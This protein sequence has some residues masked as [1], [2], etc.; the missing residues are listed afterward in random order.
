MLAFSRTRLSRWGLLAFLVLN[1]FVAV[2]IGFFLLESRAQY[3]EKAAISAQNLSQLLEQQLNASIRQIDI[4]LRSVGDVVVRAL[5]EGKS[6]EQQKL[7]GLLTQHQARQP[8][9]DRILL[10]DAR[11]RIVASS[12]FESSAGGSLADT[13]YFRRVSLDHYAGLVVGRP[14]PDPLGHQLLLPFAR[15]I[16]HSDGSFAGSLVVLAEVDRFARALTQ[17]RVGGRGTVTLLDEEQRQIAHHPRAKGERQN[18]G[19]SQLE[20]LLPLL[21]PGDAMMGNAHELAGGDGIH[22]LALRKSADWPFLIAVD[23]MSEDYLAPWYKELRF[24]LVAFLL[25]AILTGAGAYVIVRVWCAHEQA[26]AENLR[27]LRFNEALLKAIPV[28]VFFKDRDG[29][30]LGCNPAY[31]EIL[32]VAPADLIGRTTAEVWP[33][34]LSDIYVQKDR[35]LIA[36]EAPQVYEF[37][38]RDR[39]GDPRQVIFARNIF[40]DEK[41]D[42]AG[43]IGAFID[44]TERKRH[45][46]ELLAA[47]EV[48]EAASLAKSQFLATMSHEIRTPLNGILGMAQIMLMNDA[49]DGESR[50]CAQTIFNSG[51]MLLT[52]LNDILDLSKIEAG[53][54]QLEVT[55]FDPGQLIRDTLELFA[56]AAERQGVLLQGQWEEHFGH[57]YQGDPTRLRQMLGNLVSNAIKFSHGGEVRVLAKEVEVEADAAVLRFEVCDQGI[58]IP[59][60]KQALLFQ[61]FSQA[62][63]STTRKFGG[64]GLG[65]SIVRNLAEMMDGAVGVVSKIGEGACF[66]FTVR[67]GLVRERAEQ[68]SSVVRTMPVHPPAAPAASVSGHILV[69]DD[70]ATNRKVVA[71]LLKKGGHRVDC[72]ENGREADDFYRRQAP[73]LILMDCQMPVMDGFEATRRIR[74]WEGAQSWRRTPIIAFTA[75][76][77]SQDRQ[78]CVDAGMDDFLPKPV[79]A[80]ALQEM[81][82]RWLPAREICD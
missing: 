15:R 39:H 21:Q 68:A 1:G 25:F 58:G 33:T 59:E 72:V 74:R 69:V 19:N 22:M 34:H 71:A 80:S 12:G 47:R 54:L 75:G 76:V 6:L 7:Y 38:I 9:A 5:G 56:D 11:G 79:N 78:N 65:L 52:L 63:S 20:G 31:T 17:V 41:G 37:A 51:Q 43:I 23:L 61:P 29:R 30:Y 2:M 55:A 49:A 64:T 24:S 82:G 4:S 70:N 35:E 36:S 44:I 62:D 27:L 48:A 26:R 16:A 60:E 28:P 46:Q 32:G 57:H 40:L 77:F 50:D 42:V 18:A 53:K 13:D 67:V 10:L 45:E 81:L 3:S 66:W 73:D 14:Q 8:D